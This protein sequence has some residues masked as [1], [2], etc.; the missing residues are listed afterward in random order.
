MSSFKFFGKGSIIRPYDEAFLNKHLVGSSPISLGGN[1]VT[2]PPY[3]FA[4]ATGNIVL[5]PGTYLFGG[6]V[7]N[8]YSNIFYDVEAEDGMI[9]F[10]F[11]RDSDGNETLEPMVGQSGVTT[12]L[13]DIEYQDSGMMVFAVI[14]FEDLLPKIKENR[15]TMVRRSFSDMAALY[16]YSDHQTDVAAANG[17][18][19]LIHL[20]ADN[21]IPAGRYL[22]VCSVVTDRV[23]SGDAYELK[24]RFESNTDYD[25]V[26]SSKE[27]YIQ[28]VGIHNFNVLT[29]STD[30][31]SVE[32]YLWNP[33]A[34]MTIEDL[35]FELFQLC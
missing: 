3:A 34:D 6:R 32:V 9:G 12:E 27:K 22:A 19:R 20:T 8:V 1:I 28:A 13:T 33:N 25:Y 17:S 18:T 35:K 16:L 29:E 10:W 11:T 24:L 5:R 15:L 7:I 30:H 4:N 23:A 26:A 14:G 2:C 21:G 31:I